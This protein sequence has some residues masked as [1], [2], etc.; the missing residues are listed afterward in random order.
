[1]LNGFELKNKFKNGTTTL[2]NKILLDN[3]LTPTEKFIFIVI[4]MLSGKSNFC[5]AD[6]NTLCELSSQTLCSIKL[7]LFKLKKKG[8]IIVD[9][10]RKR[11]PLRRIFTLQRFMDA[12]YFNELPDDC[13]QRSLPA[14]IESFVDREAVSN[15]YPKFTRFLRTYFGGKEFVVNTKLLPNKTILIKK[16]SY[17]RNLTDK[18]DLNK[19]QA[20]EFEM[21]MWDDREDLIDKFFKNLKKKETE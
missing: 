10:N 20:V 14:P 6:N 3:N 4:E 5:Y 7:A 19:V 12:Y 1:M 2:Q 16:N 11:S 9:T 17:Y 8:Y 13:T 18:V 21:L 15:S